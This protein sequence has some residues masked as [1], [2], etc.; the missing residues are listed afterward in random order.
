MARRVYEF[1][2]LAYTSTWFTDAA[3]LNSETDLFFPQSNKKNTDF[4]LYE[5][6]YLCKDCPVIKECTATAVIRK[7][8]EGVMGVPAAKRRKMDMNSI[9]TNS[10][11][12]AF[13]E[14]ENLEPEFNRK[15][16]LVSRRCCSCYRRVKKIPINVLDWGG[17][18][19]KCAECLI[20]NKR[21]SVKQ[22]TASP[23]FNEWGYLVSKVCSRCSTRKKAHEFSKRDKGIGGVKSWCRGCMVAYEK[24]WRE[25]RKRINNNE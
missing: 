16:R 7:D 15:G 1:V 10:I 3:C 19:S 8:N 17:R 25:K 2:H 24:T 11:K 18:Q 6:H 13:N 4:Q 14:F 5:T 21:A 9:V 12:R 23:V 20:K 22:S